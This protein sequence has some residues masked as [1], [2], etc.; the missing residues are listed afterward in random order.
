M[1]WSR[2]AENRAASSNGAHPPTQN[3]ALRTQPLL[4]PVDISIQSPSC[5]LTQYAEPIGSVAIM[6]APSLGSARSVSRAFT[7]VASD[8]ASSN[9]I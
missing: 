5:R 1:N 7:T 3:P 9:D 8:R 4:V 6:A 2:P